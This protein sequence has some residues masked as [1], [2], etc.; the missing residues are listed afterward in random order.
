M[1]NAF[2]YVRDKGIVT[3]TEYPYKPVKQTCK[4]DGGP[5][6]ITSYIEIKTCN[7]LGNA[8]Q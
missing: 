8:I 7:D 3:E 1:T 2:K 4:Q 5:F 6:K